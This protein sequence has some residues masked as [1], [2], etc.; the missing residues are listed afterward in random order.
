[1]RPR[2]NIKQQSKQDTEDEDDDEDA[3]KRTREKRTAAAKRN[4]KEQSGTLFCGAKEARK[5]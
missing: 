2:K 4:G 1:L 3:E 5:I